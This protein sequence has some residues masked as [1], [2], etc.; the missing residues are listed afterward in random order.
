MRT[1]RN[2]AFLLLLGAFWI[3]EASLAASGPCDQAFYG[4]GFESF[5]EALGY[6]SSQDCDDVCYD[7]NWLASDNCQ[8]YIYAQEDTP[9][10]YVYQGINGSWWYDAECECTWDE[11]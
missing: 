9:S 7:G 6:C 2:C 11:Y 1:L 3:S 10:C 4:S 8:W 5:N